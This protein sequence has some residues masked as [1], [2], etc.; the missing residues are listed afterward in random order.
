MT[1]WNVRV[2]YK[3]GEFIKAGTFTVEAGSKADAEHAALSEAEFQ[4]KVG[5]GYGLSTGTY[6]VHAKAK[7]A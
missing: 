6:T 7:G 3:T 1:T 5:R 2:T 4:W